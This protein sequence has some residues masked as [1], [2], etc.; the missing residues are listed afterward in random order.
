MSCCS[1]RNG[2]RCTGG[3]STRR[4]R[5]STAG[6]SPAKRGNFPLR[7]CLRSRFC[8]RPRPRPRRRLC[9]RRRR[10]PRRPFPE[11]SRRFRKSS[12]PYRAGRPRSLP[13]RRRRAPC[14]R[15]RSRRILR[16]RSALRCRGASGLAQVSQSSFSYCVSGILTA[17]GSH[18]KSTAISARRHWAP[19]IGDSSP[20]PRANSRGRTEQ[21]PVN[22]RTVP[23]SGAAAPLCTLASNA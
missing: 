21:L 15:G 20:F 22:S 11:P 5:P 18:G 10:C 12:R 1:S 14:V 2:S 3:R 19:G 4:S 8:P 16:R 7:S 6:S 9:L 23:L 17:P 13:R